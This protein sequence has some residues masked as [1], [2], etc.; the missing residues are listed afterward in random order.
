MKIKKGLFLA[1]LIFLVSCSNYSN[2]NYSREIKKDLVIG[3]GFASIKNDLG[4]L[5]IER[6]NDLSSDKISINAKVKAIFYE[7]DLRKVDVSIT[8]DFQTSEVL[9]ETKYFEMFNVNS[10]SVD[11]DLNLPTDFGVKSI[12]TVS[13]NFNISKTNEIGK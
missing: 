7:A 8:E 13:G 4:N 1:S 12:E 2:Y 9:I 3:K 11:I 5:K 10:P 6:Q